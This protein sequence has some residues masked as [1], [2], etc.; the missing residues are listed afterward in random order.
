[1]FVRDAPFSIL[2]HIIKNIERV[3]PPT[4]AVYVQK[5]SEI[6]RCKHLHMADAGTEKKGL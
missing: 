3:L 6:E 2:G 5:K 1:M 4:A